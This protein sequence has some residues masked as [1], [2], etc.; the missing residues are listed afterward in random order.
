LLYFCDFA[1]FSRYKYAQV[2]SDKS[3]P[4]TQIFLEIVEQSDTI[5]ST[6]KYLIKE[7][8]KQP[9]SIF[10]KP[11]KSL[12]GSN[13]GLERSYTLVWRESTMVLRKATV[14]WREQPWLGGKLQ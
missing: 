9:K 7:A 2:G 4:Y 6:Q 13:S 10:L 11:M 14:A 8:I 3:N 12:E 1:V 5:G